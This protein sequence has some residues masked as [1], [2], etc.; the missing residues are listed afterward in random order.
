[1]NHPKPV[2]VDAD[3]RPADKPAGAAPWTRRP[4]PVADAGKA[5]RLAVIVAEG[6]ARFLTEAA[7]LTEAE[8]AVAVH[9]LPAGLQAPANALLAAMRGGK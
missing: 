7:E 5:K 1:V 2:P 9:S 8:T 6:F 3:G 4:K